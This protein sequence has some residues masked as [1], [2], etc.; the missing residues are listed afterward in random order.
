MK[1][2]IPCPP[3]PPLPIGINLHILSL[4]LAGG[5]FL[6][7]FVH[8]RHELDATS[9]YDESLRQVSPS[10][11]GS[12]SVDWMDASFHLAFDLS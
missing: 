9:G 11:F 4:P 5:F 1:D 7:I 6:T 12:L 2:R 8:K 3:T 10:I